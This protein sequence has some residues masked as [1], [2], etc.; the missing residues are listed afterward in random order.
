[1]NKR[2]NTETGYREIF[3]EAVRPPSADALVDVLTTDELF[4]R[5]LDAHPG[6]FRSNIGAL[7]QLGLDVVKSH[8]ALAGYAAD[9]QERTNAVLNLIAYAQRADLGEA[10]LKAWVIDQIARILA[11]DRYDKVVEVT[12]AGGA[13]AWDVGQEP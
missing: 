2:N 3:I 6:F 5:F 8:K 4:R 11:G 13:Y 10:P 9:L 7:Q 12:C 1:M